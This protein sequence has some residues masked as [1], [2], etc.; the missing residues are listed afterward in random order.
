MDTY[1]SAKQYVWPIWNSKKCVKADDTCPFVFASVNDWYKTQEMC[2][3]IV[4]GDTFMLKYFL[5]RYK[6]QG[7]CNKAADTFLPTLKFI[8]D[9]YVT[10]MIKTLDDL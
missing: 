2:D 9:W 8:L 6:T 5:D 4:S 10:S 7:M 3:K 1:P